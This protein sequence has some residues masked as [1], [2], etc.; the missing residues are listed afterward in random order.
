MEVCTNLKSLVILAAAQSQ[1]E[2]KYIQCCIPKTTN[3]NHMLIQNSI[4][5]LH[6]LEWNIKRTHAWYDYCNKLRL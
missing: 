4:Y 5:L 2:Y 1:L 3:N 6:Q